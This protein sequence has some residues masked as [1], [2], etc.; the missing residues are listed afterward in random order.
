MTSQRE[1]E[2][3][4]KIKALEETNA[5]LTTEAKNRE[6]PV[7]DVKIIET[8]IS[9]PS[10]KQK[11]SASERLAKFNDSTFDPNKIDFD[12]GKVTIS[13]GRF[14]WE[15]QDI[16]ELNEDILPN[17]GRDNLLT[18]IS[19]INKFIMKYDEDAK[20]WIS[21]YNSEL[22]DDVHFRKVIDDIRAEICPEYRSLNKSVV[23]DRV[24]YKKCE[25]TDEK[26]LIS[27]SKEELIVLIKNSLSQL[28]SLRK[29][30]SEMEKN[31]NY[32]R[33]RNKHFR[34]KLYT[35]DDYIELSQLHGQ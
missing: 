18:I 31:Y 21:Y 27:A 5:R 13:Y 28:Y 3:E 6:H 23:P 14:E 11:P 20:D 4:R 35:D 10:K 2:L 16:H 30:A 17:Y 7:Q 26:K 12:N 24:Q 15:D 33:G 1:L 25:V 34:R 8:Q 29:Y 22:K 19:T 32:L 9:S